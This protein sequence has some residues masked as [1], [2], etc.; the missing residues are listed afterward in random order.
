M[1]RAAV[2]LEAPGD[3]AVVSDMSGAHASVSHLRVAGGRRCWATR[4][5]IR[6]RARQQRCAKE[7]G[8]L[9]EPTWADKQGRCCSLSYDPRCRE[10][11]GRCRPQPKASASCARCHAVTSCHFLIP[12]YTA[13]PAPSL[14][15][16]VQS[17]RYHSHSLS[18][19]NTRRRLPCNPRPPARSVSVSARP[20]SCSPL[21]PAGILSAP[22]PKAVSQLTLYHHP[23]TSMLSP[24]P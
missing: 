23:E 13:F 5:S 3:R 11:A 21:K 10:G 22:R 9:Q 14:H 19:V 12:M 4:Y 16:Q 20:S 1:F 2:G 17:T 24:Q 8:C 7:R 15:S 6:P 18:P